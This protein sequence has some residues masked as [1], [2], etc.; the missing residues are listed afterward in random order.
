MCLVCIEYE[1]GKLKPL[2]GI[3]NLEEMKIH[4][5]NKHYSEIY[6]KLYEDH[7]EEELEIYY[8][9]MGFGD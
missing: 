9:M 3:H 1:K 8:E 7:L 4:I 5:D 6:N 2:E